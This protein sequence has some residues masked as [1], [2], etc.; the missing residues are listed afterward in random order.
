MEEFVEVKDKTVKSRLIGI[1]GYNLIATI[2]GESSRATNYYHIEYVAE[3]DCII[4]FSGGT[5]RSDYE[6]M[7]YPEVNVRPYLLAPQGIYLLKRG[8]IFSV[9]TYFIAGRGDNPY[10]K[11]YGLKYL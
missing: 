7:Q 9:F 4:V 6:L 10:I 11:V 8:Q 5:Q 3:D 1:D 2:G